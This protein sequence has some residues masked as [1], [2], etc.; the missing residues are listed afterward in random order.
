MAIAMKG[1][2]AQNGAGMGDGDDDERADLAFELVEEA[3]DSYQHLLTPE[4]RLVL[5]AAMVSELLDT[6]EGQRTLRSV[7]ADPIVKASKT[8]GGDDASAKESDED[9]TGT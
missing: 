6:P 1:S 7:A 8:V 9:K 3:L 4:L 5:R 2:F